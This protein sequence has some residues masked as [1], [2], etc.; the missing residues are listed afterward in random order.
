MFVAG[1]GGG[2]ECSTSPCDLD[3]AT[4]LNSQGLC[5]ADGTN[6]PA[7]A[8]AGGWTDGGTNVYVTTTTDNVGIGTQSPSSKLTVN[9]SVGIGTTNVD[10]KGVRLSATAAGVLTVGGYGNTNNEALTV[11]FEATS[12]QVDINTSTGVTAI[13]TSGISNIVFSDDINV[14]FGNSFD[15]K[16]QWDTAETNDSFKL[17][18]PVGTAA[19]SGIFYIVEAADLNTNFG[20][21]AVSNPTIRFQ[22]AD[23][24]QTSQF[25]SFVH[26]Q[27]DGMITSGAGDI[28]LSPFANVGIGTAV[29]IEKLDVA[30]NINTSGSFVSTGTGQ[31]SFNDGLVVNESGGSGSSAI[32]R[33]EGDNDVNLIYTDVVNDRVGIGS[34]APSV[35][36]EVAGVI[37]ETSD[38]TW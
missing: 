10:V 3:T 4:T 26:D 25:I 16:F 7:V 37:R 2:T 9:G 19:Q 30:G 31:S 29:P 24:T 27:S 35:K 13:K 28:V 6:C 17:G 1:S 20:G 23:A 34:T 11:G 12:D 15:A 21:A 38:A 18:I 8:S 32:F 22:S 5:L 36:L 33:V 14:A